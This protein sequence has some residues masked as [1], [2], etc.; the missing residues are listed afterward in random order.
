MSRFR[1][2]RLREKGITAVRLLSEA[3]ALLD[4]AI[5]HFIQIISLLG[6]Y[7]PEI[8]DE[9]FEPVVVKGQ[10]KFYFK[11]S[12]EEKQSVIN[13]HPPVSEQHALDENFLAS[14]GP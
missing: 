10:Q 13:H 11:M 4:V 5:E 12:T 6:E 8:H 14:I 2:T 3:R 9:I 7:A 1:S